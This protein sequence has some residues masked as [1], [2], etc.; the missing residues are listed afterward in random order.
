MT[1]GPGEYNHEQADNLT[2]TKT[3]NINLGTSPSRPN[4]IAVSG[5]EFQGAPGQ[6]DDGI[7]FN[8]GVKGFKIGEKKDERIPV[9]AG[10]GEYNH[11]RADNVTKNRTPNINM[12]TSPSRPGTVAVTGSEFQGAPGQ[13]DHGG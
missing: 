1:A 4:T 5:S 12:G 8:S 10:P 7:R 2:K 6:Y 13:Y 3:P 9:T 11:E